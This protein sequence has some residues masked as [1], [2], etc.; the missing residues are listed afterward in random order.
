MVCVMGPLHF[1]GSAIAGGKLGEALPNLAPEALWGSLE[2][3]VEQTAKLAGVKPRDVEGLLPMGELR[4]AVEQIGLSYRVAVHSWGVHAGHVG[5]L[6]RGLTDLT[7]D[8]RPPDSSIGLMRVARKLSRDKAIAAPLQNFADDIARWQE[9]LLRCRNALDED[10]G[11]LAR[12]YRRRRILQIGAIALSAL[13]MVGAIF[14]LVVVQRARARLEAALTGADPCAARAI[15]AGDL[16]QGSAAQRSEVA[17]RLGACEVEG[18]R[19]ER[20]LTEQK[21]REE[22]EREAE[23]RRAE[24]DARCEAL[25]GRLAAG[26]IASEDEALAGRGVALLRRVRDKTLEPQDLGP[27][28]PAL[29]CSGARGEDRILDAFATAAVA[30]VWRWATVADPSPKAR[31]ALS[32]RGAELPERARTML[33]VRAVETSKK[34]IMAGD[35]ASLARARRLCDFADALGAPTG[36]PC[37]AARNIDAEK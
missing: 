20:E 17:A 28:D 16:A 33:G 12:A 4:A 15:D 7:V 8:G 22:Q 29:P 2:R 21:R 11:G 37:Q 9:L 13:A 26:Q 24:L 23:R 31:E 10:A 32:K 14:Y 18:A 3:G 30:S 25:A 34:A 19:K 6:L 5:G 36:Q 35:A 27:D 1:A